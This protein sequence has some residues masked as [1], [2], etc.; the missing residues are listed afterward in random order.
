MSTSV[1]QNRRKILVNNA[2]GSSDPTIN[3]RLTTLEQNVYKIT[4][5]TTINSSSGTISIPTGATI[6]TGQFNSGI[7]AFVSTIQNS[8]PTGIFPQTSTGTEVDVSS[9]NT[10]GN[11]TLTGT[12]TS[13][14]VAL[15]YVLSIKAVDYSNLNI[16]NILEEETMETY[17][18]STNIGV[19]N[20]NNVLSGSNAYRLLPALGGNA[21][22]L[23]L[24]LS[25]MVVT[26]STIANGLIGFFTF[27]GSQFVSGVDT[28]LQNGQCR[29]GSYVNGYY[30]QVYS[31]NNLMIDFHSKSTVILSKAFIGDSITP[32]A[33]LHIAAG[34]SVANTAPI[35]LTSGTNLTT[36][37][38]G[39]IEYDG[40]NYFATNSSTR[41]ILAKTLTT[42]A[43]LDFP[44]TT[45]SSNSD[46]TITLTGAVVGDV[47]LLGVDNASVMTNSCY[48]TWVSASNTITVRFNNYDGT[49]AK[50]PTSG[51]FRVSIVKY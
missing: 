37:E 9:F 17:L 6:L 8:K 21:V 12:P 49:N 25:K 11:Y 14:P 3:T 22:I 24:P 45:A 46:L 41:Y 19:G 28:N 23:D 13:F 26:D 15:L 20:S 27:N 48:T 31:E 5:F 16:S 4:Y 39:A 51:T 38:S 35:K 42:T 50:N 7:D 2:G 18:Q 30:L 34:T 43:V 32:T 36:P 33:T 44:N 29:I 1:L 10:M 47:V 40:T